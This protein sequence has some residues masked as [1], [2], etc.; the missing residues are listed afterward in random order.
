VVALTVRVLDLCKADLDEGAMATMDE[1]SERIR[2][3][4]SVIERLRGVIRHLASLAK[5][6]A[7]RALMR[8]IVSRRDA[9]LIRSIVPG[10][11]ARHAR[12]RSWILRRRRLGN[13]LETPASCCRGPGTIIASFGKPLRR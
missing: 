6:A 8:S 2:L 5:D 9:S 1:N 13:A 4:G 10:Q 11:L 3:C 12:F 7:C